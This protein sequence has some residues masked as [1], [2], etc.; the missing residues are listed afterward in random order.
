MAASYLE[1]VTFLRL[2]T[3][4]LRNQEE[5]DDVLLVN[6]IAS[7]CATF[8]RFHK[9]V[10]RDSVVSVVFRYFLRWA[11]SVTINI[12]NVVTVMLSSRSCNT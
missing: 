4:T 8:H 5:S 10:L 12:D 6:E 3:A 2:A 9:Q 11:Y 7:K 1:E